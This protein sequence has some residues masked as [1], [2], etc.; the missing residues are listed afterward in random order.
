M[1][2]TILM[3]VLMASTSVFS[4]STFDKT[5]KLYGVSLKSGKVEKTR[6]YIGSIEK[7]LPFPI[8][9]VKNG[10]TNFTEKC[11]NSFKARR[12]FTD[13]KLD[14]KYHNE[15]LIESFVVQLKDQTAS[16]LVGR[17]VYNRGSYSYYDLVQIQE[18]M[19]EK[20]Q[21]TITVSLK[22]LSDEE[23]KTFTEIKINK[24]S[25][26]DSSSAR[27]VLTEVSPNET[28]LNYEFNA[29]TSHWILNKEVSVPQVFASFSKSINDLMKTVELE[30]S[31]HKRQVASK[32]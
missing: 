1:R 13:E 14:C 27:F 11:N 9:M 21:K 28:T 7:N 26:F 16:F 30:A 20:N 12:K 6:S 25:A 8:A 2:N 5:E 18:S 29:Q 4:Q 23:A 19:N 32:E 15:H 10:V 24:D 22:M 3:F 17:M 31:G